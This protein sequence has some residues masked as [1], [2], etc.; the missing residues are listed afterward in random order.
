MGGFPALLS[1]RERTFDLLAILAIIGAGVFQAYK[2][3]AIHS[4][5]VVNDEYQF[6]LTGLSYGNMQW[7]WEYS[8]VPVWGT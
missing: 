6:L 8:R 2:A 1:R 4:P 5:L 7:A 3:L